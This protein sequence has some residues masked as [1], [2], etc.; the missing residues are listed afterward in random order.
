MIVLTIHTVAGLYFYL[1]GVSKSK[2]SFKTLGLV[3]IGFVIL[4]LMPLAWDLPL[5]GRVILFT[6]IGVLLMS[7]AF[8]GRSKK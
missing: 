6:L 4:R 5:V 3:F 8:I 7:T 2:G 1:T